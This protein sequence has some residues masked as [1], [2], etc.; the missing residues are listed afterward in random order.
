MDISARVFP[1][2]DMMVGTAYDYPRK[3]QPHSYNL[4][5][6]LNQFPGE[7][8]ERLLNYIREGAWLYGKPVEIAG[9]GFT[10]APA[11]K[12]LP[13]AVKALPQ[14]VIEAEFIDE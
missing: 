1:S 8:I 7:A 3:S 12:E 5:L 14:G 4:E 13:S 9:E 10:L 2:Y 6:F 11:T